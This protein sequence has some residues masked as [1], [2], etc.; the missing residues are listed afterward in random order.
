MGKIKTPHN[1]IRKALY[2]LSNRCVVCNT[3]IPLGDVH[4]DV[5]GKMY[6]GNCYREM[7][8]K[9]KA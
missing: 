5:D 2:K 8:E 7:K 6:C 4:Y 9:V 1:S 3:K